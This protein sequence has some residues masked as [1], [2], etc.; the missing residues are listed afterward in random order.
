MSLEAI[1]TVAVLG[2]G[3]MG[4]GIA[5]VFAISTAGIVAVLRQ[6]QWLSERCPTSPH[7]RNVACVWLAI[8]LIV[9]AQLSWNLRPWFGSPRIKVE[10]LREHPFDG[11]FYESVFEMTK[12]LTH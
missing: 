7:T 6:R 11:T 9:G 8:N 4:H 2:A 10:F 5:H 1:K 12:H 3:T